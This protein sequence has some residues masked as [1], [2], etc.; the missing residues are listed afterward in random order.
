MIDFVWLASRMVA[1][2]CG[3]ATEKLGRGADEVMRV[4]S[5]PCQQDFGGA[6]RGWRPDL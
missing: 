4:S 5:E 2:A 1:S 6:T 3:L